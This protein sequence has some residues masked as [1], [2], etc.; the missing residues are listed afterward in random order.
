MK[1]TRNEKIYAD[2][3]FYVLE[4]FKDSTITIEYHSEDPEIGGVKFD[5]DISECIKNILAKI[6]KEQ[7]ESQ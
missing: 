7:E 2:V 4:K 1:L 5:R 6:L 3:M